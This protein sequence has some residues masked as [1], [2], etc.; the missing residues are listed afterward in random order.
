MQYFGRHKPF[1]PAQECHKNVDTKMCAN[2]HTLIPGHWRG[3]WWW[4][5]GKLEGGWHESR[6][7]VGGEE[8]VNQPGKGDGTGLS[9]LGWIQ[10]PVPG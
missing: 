6:S 10:I 7:G 3:W 9:N 2:V 4:W 5:L 1:A 8:L